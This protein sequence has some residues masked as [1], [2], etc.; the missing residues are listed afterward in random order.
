MRAGGPGGDEACID[1]YMNRSVLMLFSEYVLVYACME[2]E[3]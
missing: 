2:K 1:Q 3:C